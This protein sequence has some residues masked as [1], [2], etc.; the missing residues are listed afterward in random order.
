[1]VTS[2]VGAGHNAAARAIVAAMGLRAPQI[3]VEF[4][5]ILPHTARSFRIFYAGGYTLAV[6]PP[7]KE[8]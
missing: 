5:D 4:V 8:A 7:E 1:M 2:S 6:T 3:D